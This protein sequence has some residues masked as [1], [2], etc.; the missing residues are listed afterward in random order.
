L[1]DESLSGDLSRRYATRGTAVIPGSP[2]TPS[3]ASYLQIEPAR[4]LDHVAR[5]DYRAQRVLSLVQSPEFRSVAQ[6]IS[7][8][9]TTAGKRWTV[10]MTEDDP[11]GRFADYPD[12]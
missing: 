8:I 7:D 12:P 10:R 4:L 3:I 5:R 1:L 11:R 9:V 2:K 6:D